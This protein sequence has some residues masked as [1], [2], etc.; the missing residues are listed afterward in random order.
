M[1]ALGEELQLAT[2]AYTLIVTYLVTYSFQIVAAIIIIAIGFILG[3]KGNTLVLALC[4]KKSLDITLS[5]FFASCARIA[6]IVS[7]FVIALPKLGIQITPFVAAIGALGLGAGLAVQGLL[8]NYGAGLSIILS[9][10]FV[11]GDTIR[12]L[13]VWGIVK[14]VHLGFTRLTNEDGEIITIPNKHIVGE[15]IHN[16]HEDTMLELVIGIA[17]SSNTQLAISAIKK[18]L[19][20]L[21]GLS[22]TRAIQIGIEAFDDSSIN[23]GVRCWV[24]TE[25]FHEV[26]FAG[27]Q[28]ML[29]ALEE[30]GITIPFPQREV[31]MLS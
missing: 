11:V 3:R 13:G 8:S 1:D 16:S 15:I 5:R 17:Y 23:I 24:K 9:R 22:Q 4:E 10:P 28:A 21:E 6:I 19:S 14:E 30:I 12:L 7:A 26:K 2:E 31:R 18:K 20:E 29:A 27:N 25:L